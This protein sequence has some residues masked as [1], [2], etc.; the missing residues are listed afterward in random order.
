MIYTHHCHRSYNMYVVGSLQDGPD[1]PR[2]LVI[3][4]PLCIS[5]PH[6]TSVGPHSQPNMAEGKYITSEISICKTEASLLGLSL[7]FSLSLL[8]VRKA[9]C[10]IKSTLRQPYREVE[11]HVMRN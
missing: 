3:F 4:S 10:R 9:S 1:D 2:L 7:F 6:H 11:V 8:G 5:L